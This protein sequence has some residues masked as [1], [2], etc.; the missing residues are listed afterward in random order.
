MNNDNIIY[1]FK[2]IF[3]LKNN[4]LFELRL[5]HFTKHLADKKHK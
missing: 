5:S 1:I 2:K 3:K 4:I